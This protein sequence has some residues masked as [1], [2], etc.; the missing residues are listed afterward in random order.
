MV[1]LEPNDDITTVFDENSMQHFISC[2][3]ALRELK[4]R[5]T[6]ELPKPVESKPKEAKPQP[7]A[8][9][10]T[11]AT[12]AAQVFKLIFDGMMNEQTGA[13]LKKLLSLIFLEAEGAPKWQE[14][15]FITS[16]RIIPELAGKSH[17]L[18]MTCPRHGYFPRDAESRKPARRISKVCVPFGPSTGEPNNTDTEPRPGKG[19][20]RRSYDRSSLLGINLRLLSLRSGEI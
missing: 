14:L 20:P 3:N 13:K 16:V 4:A 18:A 17:S 19:S 10:E 9:T 2:G 5:P 11:A 8:P 6:I 12:Q 15:D 7:E 1:T